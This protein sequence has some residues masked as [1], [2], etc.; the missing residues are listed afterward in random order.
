MAENNGGET[1]RVTNIALGGLNTLPSDHDGKDGE[2]SLSYNLINE[3]GG[4]KPLRQPGVVFLLKENQRV[5]CLHKT[6]DYLH[7]IILDETNH[8]LCWREDGPYK[9]LVP[10]VDEEGNAWDVSGLTIHKVIPVGN[11]LVVLTSDG[12]RYF[13]WRNVKDDKGKVTG[14][15]WLGREVPRT[16]L[17]LY[18]SYVKEVTTPVPDKG[19][20]PEAYIEMGNPREV[21][22]GTEKAEIVNKNLT[23]ILANYNE[24]V[25]QAARDGYFTQP[26]FVRYAV[27]LYD[28]SHIHLSAPILMVPATGH[29][30]YMV[31]STLDPT[32]HPI[33]QD[34]VR[35]AARL[36]ALKHFV[37]DVDYR[38]LQKYADSWMDIVE[39][40]DIFISSPIYT[41]QQNLVYTSGEYPYGLYE[42][43][44]EME[45][46]YPNNYIHSMQYAESGGTPIPS[47]WRTLE[48]K[49]SS[50]YLANKQFF[51]NIPG[52][53]AEVADGEIL[54]KIEETSTFYLLR[55]YSVQELMAFHVE[56]K[57]NS[58]NAA[59]EKNVLP[60]LETRETLKE[61]YSSFKLLTAEKGYELNGRLAL[62]GDLTER[63]FDGYMSED[64]MPRDIGLGPIDGD[65]IF[66]YVV[67][68]KSAG[69]IVVKSARSLNYMTRTSAAGFPDGERRDGNKLLFV[70]YPDPDARWAYIDLTTPRLSHHYYR[71]PLKRHPYLNGAY[72]FNGWEGA[73]TYANKCEAADLPKESD[74][75]GKFVNLY[76]QVAS[77]A[78]N[79]P[80]L[81]PA[82]GRNAVGTG[83]VLGLAAAVQALSQGQFGQFPLYA[84][85]TEG[86]WA[87]KADAT[88]EYQAVQPVTRDVVTDGD[89]ITQ[90]D[91]SVLF[92]TERGI[93]MLAG[94]KAVCISEPLQ[95]LAT[96]DFKD[97][98]HFDKVATL[99]GLS[100][101]LADQAVLTDWRKYFL[102]GCRMI[103]DYVHQ[104]VVAY[105]PTVYH[106]D[107]P[108]AQ[109]KLSLAYVY[110]LRSKQWGMMYTDIARGINSYPSALAQNRNWEVV[111]F[112][113]AREE[114]DY[115]KD[116]FKERI[117]RGLAVTRPLGLTDP[118]A[119]KTVRDLY[120]RGMFTRGTVKTALYGTRDYYN[121]VLVSSSVDERL[122]GFSG[123]PY[124]AY[125]LVL[126]TELLDGHTVSMA[127]V[128]HVPRMLN[129]LR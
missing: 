51:Q 59:D 27:R 88:G 25:G 109:D 46:S 126:M 17:N 103:Y 14:Y 93:M 31:I 125:R 28:G 116:D 81:F 30:P 48:L 94:S 92:A 89:S 55:S 108:E 100:L 97:M 68:E 12:L 5:M 78:V 15:A 22:T 85:T 121:W 96:S 35:T 111:D 47:K 23:R 113:Q 6:A 101:D 8:R 82:S 128:N 74:E 32:A 115:D 67:L 117:N 123:T 106:L 62:F 102:K 42:D 127:S 58:I 80:F 26:F 54:K 105:N 112:S 33:T 34:M 3:D 77:S 119:L 7:Y 41:Y 29:N 107:G 43:Q 129:R 90:T 36:Y 60:T 114:M 76:S 72:Y 19:Q 95:G 99:G 73:L 65:Q 70:F 13:L 37:S 71:L 84:F 38:I 52:K 124:K 16:T 4:L 61:D 57:Y 9:D 53:C 24:M 21:T 120:V 11:T 56:G 110:S 50:I 1:P 87:M 49:D 66:M 79:M 20:G 98:P 86:V 104:R 69:T 122:T 10:L 75:K 45:E 64:M 44:L 18:L 2:L 40:I 91:D 118:D 39:G 83:R 63:M